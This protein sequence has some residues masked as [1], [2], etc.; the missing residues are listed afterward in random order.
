MG[1]I[2]SRENFYFKEL[3]LLGEDS[4]DLGDN[5]VILFNGQL[6]EELS[7]EDSKNLIIALKNSIKHR[8]YLNEVIRIRNEKIINEMTNSSNYRK[9]K[10]VVK[11]GFIYIV[12]CNRTKLYKIGS[13]IKQGVE[14]RV[15]QL[16]TSNPD[17]QLIT[18]FETMDIDDEKY[19]HDLFQS[20]RVTNEWFELTDLDLEE[21][22]KYYNT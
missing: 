13:T 21:I 12:K 9:S 1:K 19:F 18:S 15:N 4:G 20:K 5:C 14:K 6:Y 16:K 7:I 2:L 8:N 10:K 22:K 11:S 3:C 17:I